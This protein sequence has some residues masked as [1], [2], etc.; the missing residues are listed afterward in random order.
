MCFIS[1][2]YLYYKVPQL[3]RTQPQRLRELTELSEAETLL[4]S[5]TSH[6]ACDKVTMT[7]TRSKSLW[8]GQKVCDMVTKTVTRSGRLWRGHEDF[9]KVT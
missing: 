3:S 7:M 9:D 1:F 8:Q 4:L 2:E 5:S 6:D